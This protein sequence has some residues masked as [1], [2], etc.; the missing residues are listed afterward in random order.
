VVAFGVAAY[1]LARHAAGVYELV[2]QASAF[3]GAPILVTVTFALFSRRG[4]PRTAYAT[5][6]AGLL[7]YVAGSAAGFPYPFLGSVAVSL[8]TYLTGAGLE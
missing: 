7:A 2:Q 4:G 5:L 8:G 1:V 6:A 3:G